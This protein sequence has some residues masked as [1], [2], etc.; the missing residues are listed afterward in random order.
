M[1]SLI[2]QMAHLRYWSFASAP[3]V[4][5]EDRGVANGLLQSAGARAGQNPREAAEL[6]QAA[7][8]YLSVVR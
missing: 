1:L 8:A 4:T 6:R 2:S 3:T 7:R 5:T